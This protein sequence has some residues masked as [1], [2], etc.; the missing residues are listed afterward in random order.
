MIKSRRPRFFGGLILLC[1]LMTKPLS[2]GELCADA[3][4]PELFSVP[5][6]GPVPR[7][8][9]ESCSRYRVA[10]A[11]KSFTLPD[12]PYQKVLSRS[13][14]ENGSIVTVSSGRYR[15]TESGN[16]EQYTRN[17]RLLSINS[18]EIQGL[19][20]KLLSSRDK[21]GAVSAF[22]YQHISR[23]IFGIPMLGAVQIYRGRAGD[24]T[25][26]A[27]LTVA[28][29][30]A[31]GIPARAVVGMLLSPDFGGRRDVFVFHMW[32]EALV[33]GKWVL[34]DATRPRD[35]RPNRYIAL[36][37]HSLQTEMPLSYLKA[38]A[39][40]RNLSVQYILR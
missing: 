27:V 9:G 10:S 23:K 13:T 4:N 16:P 8:Y 24:C 28:V 20:K 3:L 11:E 29:L 25:E 6:G 2:Q 19:R 5:A 26:H 1:V 34:V 12:T 18:P 40:I 22:V 30:R 37:Y 38:V 7:A 35:I 17:T 15:I 39:S 14:G 31:L 21:P 36:S 33:N 32:A